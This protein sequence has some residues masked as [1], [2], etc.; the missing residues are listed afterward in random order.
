MIHAVMESVAAEAFRNGVG[1]GCFHG[2]D[3]RAVRV[4]RGRPG[5]DTVDMIKIVIK[6]DNECVGELLTEPIQ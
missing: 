1:S 5:A 3:I 4:R 2:F 6:Q